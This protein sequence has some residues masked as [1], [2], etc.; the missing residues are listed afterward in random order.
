MINIIKNKGILSINGV[1]LKYVTEE[2]LAKT[3]VNPNYV[4]LLAYKEEP[5]KPVYYQ[6]FC[7]YVTAVALREIGLVE[8]TFKLDNEGDNNG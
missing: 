7:D 3:K 4:I 2:I 6:R 1:I 8:F 5:N